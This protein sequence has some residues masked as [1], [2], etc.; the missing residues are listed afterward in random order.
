M[1]HDVKVQSFENR[2]TSINRLI[3]DNV[4]RRII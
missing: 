4:T 3:E 1:K 2:K